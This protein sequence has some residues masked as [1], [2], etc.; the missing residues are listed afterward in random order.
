MVVACSSA[1][2]CSDGGSASSVEWPRRRR[3]EGQD[4]SCRAREGGGIPRSRLV[5]GYLYALEVLWILA[6]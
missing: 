3:S 5:R 6:F 4:E 1:A 2:A